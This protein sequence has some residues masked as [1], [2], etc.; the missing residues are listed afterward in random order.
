MY[1]KILGSLDGSKP[2][3]CVLNHAEEIAK[4]YNTRM[5]ILIS[6]TERVSRLTQRTG[7][8]HLTTPLMT[9]APIIEIPV[10][11]DKKQ[12]QVERYLDKIANRLDKKGIKGRPEVLLRQPAE[13]IVHYA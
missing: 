12:K 13:E 7:T 2:A 1:P 4:G 8:T 6:V 5:V 3:E 11:V 9:P 10:P